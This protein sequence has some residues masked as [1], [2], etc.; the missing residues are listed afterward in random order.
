MGFPLAIQLSW[1]EHKMT[2]L[3]RHICERLGNK[4][5]ELLLDPRSEAQ[6]VVLL[7]DSPKDR[8]TWMIFFGLLARRRHSQRNQ[9]SPVPFLLFSLKKHPP[10]NGRKKE[11]CYYS[12]LPRTFIHN[13]CPSQFNTIVN[14][15][16][17]HQSCRPWKL[18]IYSLSVNPWRPC[19]GHNPGRPGKRSSRPSH[20]QRVV[21]WSERKV[22]PLAHGNRTQHLNAPT[23]GDQPLGEKMD[24]KDFT[25]H[26]RK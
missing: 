7:R 14:G 22:C 6:V 25:L 8:L 11:G 16:N 10:A 2:W 23:Q 5:E 26:A 15:A 17:L 4:H 19:R 12:Q 3:S 20:L 9:S 1:R 24:S 18:D 13:W 21:R